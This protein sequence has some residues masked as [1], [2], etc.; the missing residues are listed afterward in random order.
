MI[1]FTKKDTAIYQN[2]YIKGW[3]KGYVF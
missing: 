1:I 2:G 3:K